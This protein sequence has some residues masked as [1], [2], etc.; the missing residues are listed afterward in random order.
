MVRL[1][2]KFKTSLIYRWDKRPDEIYII[3]IMERLP[4]KGF[5]SISQ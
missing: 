3:Q 4:I 5:N 1:S 2:T